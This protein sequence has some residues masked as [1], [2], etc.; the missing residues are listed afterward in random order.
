MT[1]TVKTVATTPV[2]LATGP[3]TG[4]VLVHVKNTGSADVWV[5]GPTVDTDGP[6][7]RGKIAPGGGGNIELS[8]TDWLYGFTVGRTTVEVTRPVRG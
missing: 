1:T 4:T 8:S 3:E 2:L 7:A 5:G 6:E